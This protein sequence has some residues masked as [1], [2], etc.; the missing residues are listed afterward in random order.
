VKVNSN[1]FAMNTAFD[2]IGS[3]SPGRESW[4][5]K[6]RVLRLWSVSSFMKPNQANSI[7]MV[8]I[9]EKVRRTLLLTYSICC[10]FSFINLC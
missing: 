4:R 7:E 2:M 9:D 10:V 8:L 6:V 1:L 5:F 3:V